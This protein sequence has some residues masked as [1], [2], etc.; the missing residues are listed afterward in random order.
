MDEKELASVRKAFGKLNKIPNGLV[1]K[2][3][4]GV[5]TYAAIYVGGR[6]YITGTG[7]WWGTNVFDHED[8]IKRVIESSEKIE[9]ATQWEAL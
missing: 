6:W 4:S 9:I 1:I 3:V 7:R 5:Y 8:F 2:F